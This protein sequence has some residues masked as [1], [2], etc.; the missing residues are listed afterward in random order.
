MYAVSKMFTK[1][2]Q[3]HYEYSCESNEIDLIT[4]KLWAI[5]IITSSQ[6]E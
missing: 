5:S 1:I 3:C 4:L 6:S 2:G